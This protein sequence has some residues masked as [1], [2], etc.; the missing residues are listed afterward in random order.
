MPEPEEPT[1]TKP[2]LQE[3]SGTK[4]GFPGGRQT[5]SKTDALLRV[6]ESGIG[7]SK[8]SVEMPQ[9][10]EELPPTDPQY[11]GIQGF[12]FGDFPPLGGEVSRDTTSNMTIGAKEAPSRDIG[13]VEAL[14][15]GTELEGKVAPDP[16]GKAKEQTAAVESFPHI[17]APVLPAEAPAAPAQQISR[18][19]PF[20]GPQFS[21]KDMAEGD[22]SVKRRVTPIKGKRETRMHDESDG[23]WPEDL[24]AKYRSAGVQMVLGDPVIQGIRKQARAVLESKFCQGVNPEQGL[25]NFI[26]RG[27]FAQGLD[28]EF[29]MTVRTHEPTVYPLWSAIYLQDGMQ[30]T[31]GEKG[32]RLARNSV[33]PTQA[34]VQSF[35]NGTEL[36]ADELE[37]FAQGLVILV[38]WLVHLPVIP[39]GIEGWIAEAPRT[40][41]YCVEYR[42]SILGYVAAMAES[43]MAG[44]CLLNEQSSMEHRLLV[45]FYW[46]L[47]KILEYLVQT[48]CM[49]CCEGLDYMGERQA[50]LQELWDIIAKTNPAGV[51]TLQHRMML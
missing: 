4:N 20:R 29:F 18:P 45:E 15:K 19:S 11:Q 14:E 43:I 24:Q 13:N 16:K 7:K 49:D 5:R 23:D 17:P 3:L 28:L 21:T 9:G 31:A 51:Q 32:E 12:S 42:L 41:K 47:H 26:F 46:L 2:V 25:A 8:S 39:P 10:F 48:N 38:D 27:V 6:D 1:D 30:W 34:L 50:G 33:V 36:T 37:Q 40:H 22:I 35:A 44:T